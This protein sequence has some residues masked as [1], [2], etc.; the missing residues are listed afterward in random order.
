V[1]TRPQMKNLSAPDE[2]LS[3]EKGSA[4]TVRVGELVV[5]RLVL[6]PGWRWSKHVRPIVGTTSCQFHHVGFTLSGAMD[7]RMDDGTE[8]EVRSGDIFD[9]PPGHDNWVIGNEPMV[10]ILWG[11]WR[12]W[13]KP[14]VGER[15]L[16]T[17]LMTDIAGST[18]RASAVGDSAWDQ[19]L[20]RHHALVR[21]ILERYRGTEIDTAGD[22]FLTMFDGAA[23]AVQ[24]ALEIRVAV[25]GI[26]LDIRAGVHT[27]EVEV[28]PGG[29]RGLAVHETARIMALGNAGDILVS[30]TTRELSDGSGFSY[31]DRGIHHL[32]GIPAPRR[33]FMLTVAGNEQD[34]AVR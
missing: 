25:R 20:D 5:G 11:G 28:V 4:S 26:G 24:S 15:I 19:L 33:V 17:M 9:V 34:G 18:D 1:D 3:L 21:E 16:T 27:G 30:S 31:Q 23:R 29:I 13:G 8:F 22:G 10:A 14:P 12:G 7:G 6:E 2:T 32:K